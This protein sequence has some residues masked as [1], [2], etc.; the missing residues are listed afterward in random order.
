MTEL[1]EPITNPQPTETTPPASRIPEKPLTRRSRIKT[2]REL[3]RRSEE[4]SMYDETSG[5]HSKKWLKERLQGAIKE[6][7][8]T[9][10]NFYL[11]FI[12]LD[13]FKYYNSRHGHAGGDMV[14]KLLSTVG[15]RPGEEI[16]RV[17][18]D[19]FAQVLNDD[20]DLEQAV[21]A[22]SRNARA[23]AD[24]SKKLIPTLKVINNEVIPF[25]EVTS[26]LGLIQYRPGMTAESMYAEASEM[27][28][29]TKRRGKDLISVKSSEGTI[30]Y[31]DREGKETTVEDEI[32][33]P[34]NSKGAA[35]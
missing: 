18:G 33:E 7:E 21:I 30:R 3:L 9:G 24:E 23:I 20:I 25:E 13:D 32:E 14:L 29:D 28:L 34:S 2:F 35:A 6:S 12:D 5:V 19:E 22:S 26:T 16:A 10:K 17:G 27:M 4:Q 11:S 8:R 31:F 1:Q 15:T